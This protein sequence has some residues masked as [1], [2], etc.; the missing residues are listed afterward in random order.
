MFVHLT[1]SPAFMFT[2]DGLK[3]KFCIVTLTVLDAASAVVVV[4]GIV[5]VDA[6]VVEASV[7]GIVVGIVVGGWL[8]NVVPAKVVV[9]I[10]PCVVVVPFCP[11]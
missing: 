10:A 9:V 6:I 8:D 3:A 4:S 1:V 5:V 7:V 11:C 2:V